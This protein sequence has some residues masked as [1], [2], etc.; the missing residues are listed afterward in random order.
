[1]A[2]RKR[3]GIVSVPVSL[4]EADGSLLQLDFNSSDII[5]H[6]IGRALATSG[7]RVIPPALCGMR[8]LGA[9]GVKGVK[10][11]DFLALDATL[12]SILID[13]CCP[14]LGLFLRFDSL[15]ARHAGVSEMQAAAA[16]VAQ[17]TPEWQLFRSVSVNASTLSKVFSPARQREVAAALA[18]WSPVRALALSQGTQLSRETKSY[19]DFG[20]QHEPEIIQLTAAL[21][22][23]KDSYRLVT[24][25]L[26]LQDYV[27]GACVSLL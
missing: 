5:S 26:V 24:A 21:V 10:C 25:G 6:V 17:R 27:S 19:L 22:F 11:Q 3:A 23:A 14:H 12:Q 9:S 15:A 18:A 2:A 20:I 13:G 8:V 16:A 1:M 7:I 4:W